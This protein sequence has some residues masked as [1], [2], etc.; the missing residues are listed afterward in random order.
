MEP[1]P[2]QRKKTSPLSYVGFYMADIDV[3]KLKALASAACRSM[4]AQ[5]RLLVLRGL[6]KDSQ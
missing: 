5:A 1:K 4:S 2:K 3:K 6:E